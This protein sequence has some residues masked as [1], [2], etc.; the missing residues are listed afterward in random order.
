MPELN[1]AKEAYLGYTSCCKPFAASSR[2]SK[3][4]LQKGCVLPELEHEEALQAE[5]QI[6]DLD[7]YQQ[8]SQAINRWSHIQHLS[9]RTRPWM[10]L[11]TVLAVALFS[12]LLV[13]SVYLSG[14][15]HLAKTSTARGLTPLNLVQPRSGQMLVVEKVVYVIDGNGVV[16]ALWARH[17]YVYLLWQRTM[18]PFS[19]FIRVDQNVVYLASP[20][21][22]IVAL[23]ASDGTV[24]WIQEG[25]QGLPF[26]RC[27]CV[28]F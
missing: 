8:N 14:A 11:F 26:K 10:A 18:T 21:G 6:T 15:S 20:D 22:S 16:T 7:L 2:C 23:R 5:Y 12:W 17:R 27:S 1:F 3:D 13:S 28:V 19:Q 25:A 4:R 9:F 24:L